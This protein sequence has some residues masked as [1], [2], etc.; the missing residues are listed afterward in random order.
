MLGIFNFA[1]TV[2]AKY[3]SPQYI[4]AILSIK[5]KNEKDFSVNS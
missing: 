3:T 4:F 5:P 1:D 2:A